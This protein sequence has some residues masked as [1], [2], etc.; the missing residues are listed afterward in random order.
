MNGSPIRRI[1]VVDDSEDSA[2]AMAMLLGSMGHETQTAA[3][4]IAAVQL[5]ETFRPHVILMDIGMPRMDGLE[6]ARAIRTYGWGRDVV[7]IALSGWGRTIDIEEAKEAG[8]D[9]HLTK[10]VRPNDLLRALDTSRAADER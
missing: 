8:C 7:I 3:D 5:A 10:P 4:G 2:D 6:A 9:L 1:L